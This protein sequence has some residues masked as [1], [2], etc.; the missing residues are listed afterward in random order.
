MPSSSQTSPTRHTVLPLHLAPLPAAEFTDRDGDVW[1]AHGNNAAGEL[2]L[3]CTNPSA[4][5]DAGNGESYPWTL[6]EVAEV[7]GPLQP[8]TEVTS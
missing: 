5:A 7:F 4:T 6:R 8:R 1:T 3:S 2:V